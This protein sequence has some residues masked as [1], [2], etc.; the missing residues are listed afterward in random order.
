MLRI[1][2]RSNFPQERNAFNEGIRG[3]RGG[4]SGSR[5]FSRI[6]SIMKNQISE[7]AWNI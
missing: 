7:L 4:E 3:E 1:R 2:E 5:K 6:F